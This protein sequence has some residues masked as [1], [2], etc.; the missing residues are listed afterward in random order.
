M[1]SKAQRAASR[2]ARLSRRRRR[3][4]AAPQDFQA[5]P[6]QPTAVSDPA[7]AVPSR[8]VRQAST[9]RS[10][11]ATE[12]TSR[13]QPALRSRRRGADTGTSNTNRYLGRELRQIGAITTLIAV[14]LVG[15]TFVLG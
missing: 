4:K 14:I 6:S 9:F 11:V 1:P 5:V 13:A 10:E 7:A 8:P 2:Q 15:L 12:A 3:G